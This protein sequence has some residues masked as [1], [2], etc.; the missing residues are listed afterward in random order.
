MKTI[1][2]TQPW[3]TLVAIG[4]KRIETRSWQIRYRGPLVIHAAKG[5]TT[6]DIRLA[7]VEPFKSVLNAAGYKLFTQLP[8]GALVA[9][10]QLVSVIPVYK[11]TE[12]GFYQWSGPDGRNY[13]FELTERERTFGNYSFGRY[14]WLLDDVQELPLPIPARGA[15]GLWECEL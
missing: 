9:T 10:C 6:D 14:A 15:Q 1:T 13:R 8:R 4:A 12:R 7:F 5:A 11:I 2:L 3:A